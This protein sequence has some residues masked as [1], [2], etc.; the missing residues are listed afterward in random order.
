[1][2]NPARQLAVVGV[3]ADIGP[4]NLIRAQFGG[5]PEVTR[6]GQVWHP[7]NKGRV[8]MFFVEDKDNQVPLG[9]I[10]LQD[11]VQNY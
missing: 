5:S 10:R 3:M 11:K 8:V 2:I 7:E 9:I 4:Y 1:M 6:F